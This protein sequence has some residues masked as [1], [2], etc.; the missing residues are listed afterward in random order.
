MT[1]TDVLQIITQEYEVTDRELPEQFEFKPDGNLVTWFKDEFNTVW[2][3]FRD[4][5]VGLGEQCIPQ[6]A[7]LRVWIRS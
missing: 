6:S 3:K 7:V 1:R 5:E 2:I 4:A